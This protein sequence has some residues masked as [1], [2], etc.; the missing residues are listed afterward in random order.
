MMNPVPKPFKEKR[1]FGKRHF[2]LIKL[3]TILRG[4]FS[5]LFYLLSVKFLFLLKYK[6]CF[7]LLQINDA[8]MSS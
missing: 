7:L 6:H 3:R 2:Y 8:L 5:Y 4:S 1:S